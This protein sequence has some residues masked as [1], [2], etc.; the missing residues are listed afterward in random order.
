MIS[1]KQ[2]SSSNRVS[3]DSALFRKLPRPLHLR[4]V[5]YE[6][7]RF[8]YSTIWYDC[9]P[10]ASNNSVVLLGPSMLNFAGPLSLGVFRAGGD[11]ILSVT[12]WQICKFH[13]VLISVEG[14]IEEIEFDCG[15]YSTDLKVE[16][17]QPDGFADRLLLLPVS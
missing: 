10:H 3:V 14:A 13:E 16:K 12:P 5:G 15:P 4:Q 6:E 9:F 7:E 17:N 11:G 2:N 8:D 1:R